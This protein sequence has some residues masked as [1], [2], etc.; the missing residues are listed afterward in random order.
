MRLYLLFEVIF[1]L[2]LAA[3]EDTRIASV[4]VE[5][6]DGAYDYEI[7]EEIEALKMENVPLCASVSLIGTEMVVDC[8]RQEEVCAHSRINVL[9]D[10]KGHICGVFKEL[11]GGFDYSVYKNVLEI[12]TNICSSMFK[13]I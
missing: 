11:G 2:Y 3:L 8:D 4:T 7:G 1:N 9:V 5:S 6:A 10:R 12:A 13:E